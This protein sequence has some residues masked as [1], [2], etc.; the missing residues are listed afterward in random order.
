MCIVCPGKITFMSLGSLETR[1]DVGLD[2]F[3]HVPKVNRAIGV[4]Q[5][6]GDQDSSF[7]FA[8]SFC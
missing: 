7:L 4:G 2:I 3:Q 8:H 1:P 5:G 6:A